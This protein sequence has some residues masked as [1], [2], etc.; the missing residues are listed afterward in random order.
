MTTIRLQTPINAPIDICFDLARSIDLH[1]RSMKDSDEVAIAGRK[2]GLIQQ[3]ETVT[4]K[5]RHFGIYLRMTVAIAAMSRPTY[6]HDFMLK[7]PF[8]VMRH[9]HHFDH[10]NG[11]T[12]M[13]DIFVYDVPFGVLGKMADELFLRKYMTQLLVKRNAVIKQTAENNGGNILSRVI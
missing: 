12:R 8:R 2:T 10:A 5:A 11:V 9:D 4:W 13:E 7:G 1:L 3:G 6:F